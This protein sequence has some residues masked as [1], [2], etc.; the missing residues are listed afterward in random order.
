MQLSRL[1]NKQF[2]KAL[3]N[4]VIWRT[5]AKANQRSIRCF[6]SVHGD[7][8]SW[9]YQQGEADRPLIGKT[10][11]R[12]L[13]EVAEEHADRDAAVFVQDNER[14]TF[15]DLLV[16]SDT[17][18]AGLLSLGFKPG[19]RIGIWA[20]NCKFW[21]IA[22]YATAKV[23]LILVN[24]NPAYQARELE[25]ALRKVQCRG[26]VAAEAFKTQDYYAI[27][28]S[29]CP[30]LE[31]SEPNDL[32]SE[33]LPDLKSVIM[34]SEKKFAG[35]LSVHDVMTSGES[36][37]FYRRLLEIQDNVQFDDPVNIQF[38]SGT[39]GKPK[40]VLLSHH[41]MVNNAYFC[42]RRLNYHQKPHRICVP[43]P[44][45][46]C[47]GMVVGSLHSIVSAATAVY[48]SNGFKPEA[49]LKSIEQ[50]RCTSLLGTPTMFIDILNLPNFDVYTI[51]SLN[52]GL[53]GG[54]PCPINVVKQ[55]RTKLHMPEVTIAYGTTENSPLTFQTCQD[56]TVERQV[57][58]IGRPLPH[59][60]VKV[61][62]REGRIVPVNT[63]GELCI[64]GYVV[65]HSYYQD[66]A[67]TVE[68]L[69]S[70]RWY[71]TGDLATMDEHS[72]AKIVG[73]IK[74]LIIRG[75]EN[76]YPLEVEQVLYENSKIE[77]V[78]VV[79]VPDPR[80]QE[81]VCAWIKLKE[82]QTATADE[83]KEFCKGKLSYFKIPHYIQFVD[84]F[85]LT[86]SGKIQKYKIREMAAEQLGLCE[87]T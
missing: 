39:T 27:L 22:Q 65:M 47:F 67:A 69:G 80:L 19:D 72:Y 12:M 79:G 3:C 53:I 13:R 31:T 64:R 40:A 43:V 41:N 18:G 42:T 33:R 6:S 37:A 68:V 66:E 32:K 75:G 87:A 20:P 45:Y 15:E 28:S 17:F 76:I 62:D 85:P 11:G 86:V 55:I 5:H 48:P 8:I 58:T 14:L 23:G 70:D 73:R 78:Q 83:I 63:E 30:E 56:D 24:F 77:D 57:S 51:D 26:I 52:T 46:H 38:T 25:Y 71:K 21:V 9:S 36:T 10:I 50:E 1:L 34:I 82:G 84:A 7:A 2:S 81:Q 54:S 74:D 35:A 44:L 16:E 61:V 49:C 4:H 29:I 59:V 60:E